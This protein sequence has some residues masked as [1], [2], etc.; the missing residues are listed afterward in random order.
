MAFAGHAFTQERQDLHLL[1][2]IEIPF[3]LMLRALELHAPM[4]LL[5]PMHL[6]PNHWIS[7]L[8]EMLSGLW[9]HWQDRLQPL[10]NTVVL[11][12]GPSSV[13]IL[14]ISS[15]IASMTLLMLLPRY[16]SLLLDLYVILAYP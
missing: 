3:S 5:Q 11:M 6:D 7:L 14:W 9:H 12:P 16:Y 4:Q 13:D 10:K 2:S 1:L 8:K 15:I